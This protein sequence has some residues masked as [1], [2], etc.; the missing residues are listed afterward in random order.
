M[1]RGLLLLFVLL[2]AANEVN[3][4][5]RKCPRN[6]RCEDRNLV[7]VSCAWL[8]YTTVPEDIPYDVEHLSLYSNDIKVLRASDLRNFTKL[9]VLSLERNGIEE[10]EEGSFANLN[11][12]KSLS[13]SGNRLR[14]LPSQLFF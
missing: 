10:I 12:L 3:G 1:A 11:H 2:L 8:G 5:K 13:L 4:R 7:Y 9:E 14:R 6:C